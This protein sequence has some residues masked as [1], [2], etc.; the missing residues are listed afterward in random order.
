MLCNDRTRPR[1]QKQKNAQSRLP[2]SDTRTVFPPLAPSRDHML[3][4][5]R[6]DQPFEG[7]ETY[8]RI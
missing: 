5:D 6:K 1:D 2:P 7:W 3:R 4:D 8:R